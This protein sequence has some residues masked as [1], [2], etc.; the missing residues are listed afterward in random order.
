MKTPRF[1]N[2]LTLTAI[3]ITSSALAFC[4]FYVSSGDAKLFNQ[5]SQVII[6]RDSSTSTTD[7]A[8]VTQLYIQPKNAPSDSPKLWL[9]GFS[10]TALKAGEERSLTFS[11]KTRELGLVNEQGERQM[12]GDSSLFVGGS[13]P[14]KV[15]YTGISQSFQIQ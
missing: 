8:E 9:A 1:I 4:G 15:G 5:A 6:A 14:S 3:V 2:L 12:P 11:L 7:G 10:R 13:Q